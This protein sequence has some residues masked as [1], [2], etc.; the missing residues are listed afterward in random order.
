MTP[1]APS[2]HPPPASLVEG[3]SS[4]REA[5]A[6]DAPLFRAEGLSVSF[7]SRHGEFAAIR[8]LELQIERREALALVGESGCGKSLT[9]L[10]IIGLVPPPGRISAGRLLFDGREL[11]TLGAEEMRRLRGRE[12][13]M[14]FQEPAVSLNP[15]FTVEYQVGEALRS[16]RKLSRAQRREQILRLLQEVGIPDPEAR[17]HAY[18]AQL[19]GGLRQRVMIAIA[20]A[21]R[22]KL[23]IADEPTTA[24]DVTVQAQILELLATLRAQE[25]M[26]LLLITHDL[27]VVARHAQRVVVMYAGYAVEEAPTRAL[28]RH[29]LHPYTKALLASMPGAPGVRPGERLAAVTGHVPHPS[30]L[31]SGCPFRDRCTVAI[32]ACAQEVPHL[33]EAC[34][35]R[36]VRCVR[37][38]PSS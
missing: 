20:I 2:P 35:G 38:E 23:L 28:F 13:G 33:R 16:D 12:I 7:P 36:R 8:G 10:S 22:P 5:L 17:L 34:P 4:R 18:P 30:R 11:S 31:P 9:A 32:A 15:V 25:E 1:S 29:P 24:L 14:V 37:A 19:S 3:P 26:A 6:P 21:C 27:G